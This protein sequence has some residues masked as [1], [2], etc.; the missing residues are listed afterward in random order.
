[1]CVYSWIPSEFKIAIVRIRKE[2]NDLAMKLFVQVVRET[3]TV[4]KTLPIL[5]ICL[6]QKERRRECQKPKGDDGFFSLKILEAMGPQKI[7][8]T[9]Y[10]FWIIVLGLLL[11]PEARNLLILCLLERLF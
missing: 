2:I 1:M 10:Q 6:L 3:W 5:V 11:E 8:V 9:H 7:V 4:F